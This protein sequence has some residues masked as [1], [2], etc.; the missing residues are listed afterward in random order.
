MGPPTL[1]AAGPSCKS[2]G[3][4][5][6]REMNFKPQPSTGNSTAGESWLAEYQLADGRKL[7][8]RHVC[9]DDEPLIAESIAT[10]SRE[11]LLHRFFSPIR[12][13]SPEMLRRMLAID[14]SR[15]VCIVGLVEGDDPKLVCGARYVRLER[16]GT[17][18][19][20]I[21][22]HDQFQRRGLGEF[23]LRLIIKMGR[24]DGLRTFEAYVMNS[25]VAML[26]LFARVAPGHSRR[27]YEGDVS[28]IV[29]DLESIPTTL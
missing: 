4:S 24:T 17:A 14:R 25:N 19:V 22:V 15:E 3:V 5:A 21:T 2:E 7:L 9:P 10:A 6:E 16:P 11:T 13:V 27:H 28:R 26:K 29:V 20:A 1:L 18:E 23:L 8:F 12:R